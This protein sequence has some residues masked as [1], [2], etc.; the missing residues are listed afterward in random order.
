MKRYGK[1]ILLIILCLMLLPLG[2]ADGS[3]HD[4]THN[5][6]NEEQTDA[7]D[8]AFKVVLKDM[9]YVYD[10][11][12]PDLTYGIQNS[13]DLDENHHLDTLTFAVKQ[14]FDD[15]PKNDEFK[16]KDDVQNK[17]VDVGTYRV[18]VKS[19]GNC[20]FQ[21][22]DEP[23]TERY[24][25][26]TIEPRK[27][28]FE[29]EAVQEDTF[30]DPES[31]NE[32]RELSAEVRVTDIKVDPDASDL[33][34]PEAMP[35]GLDGMILSLCSDK[36]DN[37]QQ[38]QTLLDELN[39][40]IKAEG[41]PTV[42][43]SGT[44]AQKYNVDKETADAAKDKTRQ[45]LQEQLGDNFEVTAVEWGAEPVLEIKPLE[46]TVTLGEAGGEDRTVYHEG[47]EL[48]FVVKSVKDPKGKELLASLKDPVTLAQDKFDAAVDVFSSD[49][50]T[51]DLGKNID[52]KIENTQ[53][54]V[55]RQS[56]NKEDPHLSDVK[57]ELMDHIG[58]SDA[59]YYDGITVE[60]KE[61]VSE[62]DGE[63]KQIEPVLY[64]AKANNGEGCTLVKDRDYKVRVKSSAGKDCE[65]VVDADMYT[66]TITGI[67]NYGGTEVKMYEVTQK[68]YE[69]I[70]EI[71]I[72]DFEYDH[73]PHGLSAEDAGGGR[74]VYYD[75]YG[76]ELD[77]A[78]RDVGKYSA[79]VFWDS[80]PNIA[81]SESNVETF[82]ITPLHLTIDLDANG[83]IV[84]IHKVTQGRP[85]DE[86]EDKWIR[87]ELSIDDSGIYKPDQTSRNIVIDDVNYAD[88]QISFPDG[89]EWTYGG[90]TA[91]AKAHIVTDPELTDA[92]EQKLVF[93]KFVDGDKLERCD[94]SDADGPSD[95]GKYAVAVE[96]T[97]TN[98]EPK[99]LYFEIKPLEVTL[100]I[101]LKGDPIVEF[102]ADPPKHDICIVG[103]A[104]I[105]EEL[106]EELRQEIQS[107]WRVN[108][109]DVKGV[110]SYTYTLSELEKS[111]N[112]VYTVQGAK[113]EFEVE[114]QPLS[115]EHVTMNDGS[116]MES[117][118]LTTEPTEYGEPLGP[119]DDITVT[120]KAGDV[121]VRGVD[122][123]L[124]PVNA[125]EDPTKNE[126]LVV[127]SGN[128]EGVIRLSL[129][130]TPMQRLLSNG[131]LWFALALVLLAGAVAC[132][133]TAHR[134]SVRIKQDRLKLLDKVSRKS[135]RT[136][137]RGR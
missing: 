75:E 73:E 10:G 102:G 32:P 88:P 87:E 71:T 129:P 128:Y 41:A 58:E 67:G 26:L 109:I 60:L 118:D 112:F 45:I 4:D 103:A 65:Q 92:D 23:K 37:D 31:V 53:I 42:T 17:P 80:D 83:R 59:S 13:E 68:P 25:D 46:V 16:A 137:R 119:R 20:T 135:S 28:E 47:T 107:K 55:Y 62:Y 64:D 123:E 19:S 130:K 39:E 61:S 77:S 95:V 120:N 84:S 125:P 40:R 36:E 110:G 11:K 108:D 105:S 8:Q 7:S 52:C 34:D 56:I 122:Y 85:A 38:K 43:A 113:A 106:R 98:G 21:R 104:D 126:L 124:Y 15:K 97:K 63:P 90:Q 127:G 76:K 12:G 9:S 136:I 117:E 49:Q 24:Y 101:E 91:G 3:E 79:K 86:V 96:P 82:E 70:K 134:L 121:L 1:F 22:E 69:G 94:V 93:Y 116:E 51:V 29:L 100:S 14:D 27:V 133:V 57:G 35:Q 33:L 78:P 50:V 5:E 54:V 132:I 6:S 66:V 74:I 111:D 115:P 18:H 114:K 131:A 2:L 48:S 81:P 72:P 30:Y 89:N 44:Q 99:K